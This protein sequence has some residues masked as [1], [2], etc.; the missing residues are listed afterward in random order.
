MISSLFMWVTVIMSFIK[1]IPA[2]CVYNMDDTTVFL[3]QMFGRRGKRTHVSKEVK[4]DLRARLLSFRSEF[5]RA[6]GTKE[7]R[8]QPTLKQ[9]QL[10]FYCAHAATAQLLVI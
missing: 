7:G 10:K 6:S 4:D 5:Q 3:E 9:E 1:P 8:K 2:S